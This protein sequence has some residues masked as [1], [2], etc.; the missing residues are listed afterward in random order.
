MFGSDPTILN[1][2]GDTW[3][4]ATNERMIFMKMKVMEFPNFV[5]SML[6]GYY[7][8][9]SVLEKVIVETRYRLHYVH[10]ATLV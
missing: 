10:G 7:C 8:G 5:N 4:A 6:H 9:C 3:L 2:R 1:R